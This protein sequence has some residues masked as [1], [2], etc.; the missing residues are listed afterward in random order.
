VVAGVCEP[1]LGQPVSLLHIPGEEIGL[2]TDD[3]VPLDLPQQGQGVRR[4]ASQGVGQR[5]MH[6]R[7]AVMHWDVGILSQGHPP[8]EQRD[9]LVQGALVY[10]QS[11]HTPI[12]V[13]AI[14]G[15]IEHLGTLECL[16]AIDHPVGK[17]PQL[18]EARH[19]PG[20]SSDRVGAKTEDLVAPLPLVDR[21]VLL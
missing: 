4:A 12:D 15:T 8:F 5:Q 18:A 10:M 17:G 13:Q 14:V 16:V 3:E 2:P 21:Q 11:P 6:G 20:T 7:V 1:L 9:S 19:H